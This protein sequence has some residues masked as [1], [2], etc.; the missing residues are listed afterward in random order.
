M[1]SQFESKRFLQ[2]RLVSTF[3]INLRTSLRH[4]YLFI[5]RIIVKYKGIFNQL[6]LFIF[7]LKLLIIA[8]LYNKSKIII[9]LIIF[10]Q[11][12]T[13]PNYFLIMN[14]I[15]FERLDVNFYQKNIRFAKNHLISLV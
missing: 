6:T 4:R 2:T 7:Y 14:F 1:I 15:K 10:M 3:L 12:L 5:I 13:P 9:I 8:T 11:Y